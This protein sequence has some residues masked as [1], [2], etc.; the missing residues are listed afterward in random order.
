MAAEKLAGAVLLYVLVKGFPATHFKEYRSYAKVRCGLQMG[1]F[2]VAVELG[3]VCHQGK[4]CLVCLPAGPHETLLDV[5]G[6]IN[7]FHE[8]VIR[9]GRAQQ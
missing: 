1:E 2:C 8:R 6:V 9:Q 5:L 3:R 7:V 4:T